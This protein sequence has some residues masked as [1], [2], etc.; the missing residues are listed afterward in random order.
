VLVVHDELDLSLG[1]SRLKFGGGEAGH[2]GLRD[3]SQ[4]LGTK[5]YYRLRLGIGRPPSHFEGTGADFVLQAFAPDE[6]RMVEELLQRAVDAVRAFII[7]GPEATMN[8][9]NRK[10]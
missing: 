5:D 3:I 1:E 6:T 7:G 8:E 10:K 2:N 9:Y 4:H